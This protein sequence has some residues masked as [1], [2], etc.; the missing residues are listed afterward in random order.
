MKRDLFPFANLR[1]ILISLIEKYHPFNIRY[2]KMIVGIV[3]TVLLGAVLILGWLSSRKVKE[4]VTEDF[5]QQQLVIARHVARQVE[6]SIDSLRR[7]LQLL[8]LSPSIQYFESA[9]LSNRMEISFS[10][11]KHQGTLEIRF[12]D[13]TMEKVFHVTSDHQCARERPVPEDREY[14]T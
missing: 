11:I 5:N 6:N 14:L 7:E 4:I 8:S 13:N 12:I 10:S 3:M 9:S 2:F 1:Q